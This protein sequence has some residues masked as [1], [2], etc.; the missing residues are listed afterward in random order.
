MGQINGTTILVY[1]NGVAIAAQR[2]GSI[3]ISQDL[4]SASNKGSGGWAEH[5]NGAKSATVDFD[6]LYST[7]G[8]SAD[9]LISVIINRT[10]IEVIWKGSKIGRAHV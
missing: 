2:G 1:S 5:I 7:T 9:D 6:A 8:L 3:S 10:A 4:P